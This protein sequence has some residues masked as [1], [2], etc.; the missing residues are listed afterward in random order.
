MAPKALGV[1]SVRGKRG[2]TRV[3]LVVPRFPS[4]R[5]KHFHHASCAW[6]VL[7]GRTDPS[8]S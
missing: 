7:V 4:S 2:V 8:R 1:G 5:K 6:E 3:V